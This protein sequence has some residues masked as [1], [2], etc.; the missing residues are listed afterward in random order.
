MNH[1]P[2]LPV[3]L[4][5]LFGSLLLIAHRAAP[6]HK[7]L[8]GMCGSAASIIAALLLLALASDDVIHVYQLG[9]W[10]SNIGIVLVVDR[11]SALM[12]ALTAVLG[13][14][15]VVHASAGSDE[16]QPH[17]QAL[18]QFQVMGLSGAFLTGDLFNLFVFFEV[19]LIASYGLLLHDA[20]RERLTRAT[21]YV[22]FNLAGSALFLIA[23]A[24]LYGL[25]GTLNMAD[26]AKKIAVAPA[27]NV[28][29][30][31]SAGL[32]LLTVF[33]IKAA[34]LPLYFWL[35]RTY[36]AATPAVAALFA[37]MTKVGVYAVFRVYTLLFGAEAGPLADIAQP[38][39][40]PAGLATLALAALGALASRSL[41]GLVAYLV[42]ASAG[43]L[44]IAFGVGGP[45]ALTAAIYYLVHST[46]VAATLFLLA[47]LVVRNRPVAGDSLTREDHIH[48]RD[49]IGT[50]FLI[51]AIAVA[52]LPPLSG[53][54]AKVA[55]LD[56]VAAHP[57]G[58][59]LWA[60]ILVSGLLVIVALA[61]AGSHLF[62]RP[63]PEG[64]QQ[65]TPAPAPAMAEVLPLAML[66][67]MLLAL[68]LL[69]DPVLGWADATA[70][71]LLDPAAYI[72][73]VLGQTP[74]TRPE[75]P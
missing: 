3:L 57:S 44:F 49:S 72:D 65:T 52:A 74:V 26:L 61:R 56:A 46:L 50:V 16:R 43:T 13:A 17:F 19:L 45:A 25:V 1:L 68:A 22:V 75:A 28:A 37:V 4:P 53:F 34:L 41:R 69:A 70:A 64:M 59:W 73:A 42:V 10:Q 15:A 60:V 31:H 32:L 18:V 8:L 38:W 2:V 6:A 23:V 63:A 67:S 54:V 24:L 62:W 47:D 58:P 55:L 35:P 30:I 27:D 5:L 51:A 40:L 21:H 14:V 20:N 12:V 71:Q 29:L 36:A 66:V 48:R 39:L 11:L 7:R 33:A 9:N